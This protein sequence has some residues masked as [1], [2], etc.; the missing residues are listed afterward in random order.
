MDLDVMSD[1]VARIDLS[2][3][4]LNLPDAAA[5]SVMVNA[6]VQTLT[7]FPTIE[8]VR[9]LVGGQEMETLTH[10]TSVSGDFHRSALNLESSSIPVEDAQMVTLYFPGDTGSLIVPVTRMVAGNAD[11]DTAV[12][13][14]LKGP[15]A[16]SPL[17]NALPTAAADRRNGGRRRG[18]R[19]F[20]GGIHPP[21]GGERWRAHGPR[22]LVLT[23]TQFDGIEEVRVAVDGEPYDPG[24]DTLAV[25][26]F[27]NVAAEV[28]DQFLQ[29]QASAI[30]E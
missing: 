26:T 12:L 6:V 16:T 11:V 24:A 9:F 22:A 15:S 23:C 25:P 21:G 2:Q 14:L 13:E 8:T 1:G 18:D 7:E 28:E 19:E 3:E 30:F 5:E 17:D 4:V 27:V 29:A 20:H 10:G